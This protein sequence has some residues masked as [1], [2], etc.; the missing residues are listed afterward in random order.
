LARVIR[1]ATADDVPA[2]AAVWLD[3]A[4]TAYADIFPPEA[5]K[6][7]L[8][9]LVAALSGGVRG[10]VAENDEGIV[11][12]VQVHDDWL[13]H[14]YVRPA[15]WGRGLGRALHDAGVARGANQLWVLEHNAR[16]RAMYERWGWRLSDETRP[17]Y[18]PGA[19]LDVRYELTL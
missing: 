19:I 18:E 5:P 12:L 3:S 13:T 17:V 2:M 10:F 16:A 14:L 1:A 7:T 15:A 11:G 4:L 9:S 8:D 6:P